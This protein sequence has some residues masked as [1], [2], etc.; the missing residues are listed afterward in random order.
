MLLKP[1][2]LFAFLIF[3]A[4]ALL[5]CVY[6]LVLDNKDTKVAGISNEKEIED[7]VLTDYNGNRVALSQFR[8][9]LVLLFFGYTNC[10]DICPA[11]LGKL[12]KVYSE[13]GSDRAD[14]RFLFISIDPGRDSIQKLKSHLSGFHHEFIGLT[15][16]DEEL[17]KVAKT[18][19]AAYF[20]EE[21]GNNPTDDYLMN[22]PTSIYLISR[23]SKLI[24]RYSHSSSVKSLVRDIRERL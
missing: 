23:D 17:S 21:D 7:F 9:N 4:S 16:T 1:K 12:K 20:K 5:V 19:S 18:F 24:S 10:P 13:L 14:L 6:I 3:F 11:T 2:P 22:H 8:G 15:G